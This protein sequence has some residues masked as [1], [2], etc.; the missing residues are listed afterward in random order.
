MPPL[1][2]GHA[3]TGKSG[4]AHLHLLAWLQGMRGQACEGPS[5]SS[6]GVW[7]WDVATLSPSPPH[8]GSS[9]GPACGR[10]GPGTL[11]AQTG[12]AERAH[13]MLGPPGAMQPA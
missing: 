5:G 13:C 4:E 10:K 11:M 6:C 7:L 3:Y 12:H 9:Y 1:C 8:P 2:V